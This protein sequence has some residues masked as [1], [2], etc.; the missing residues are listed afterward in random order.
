MD[1][2]LDKKSGRVSD[3]L[4]IYFVA[5]PLN[6]NDSIITNIEPSY[7]SLSQY[8]EESNKVTTSTKISSNNKIG[9]IE[10]W[11]YYRNKKGVNIESDT[12][13]LTFID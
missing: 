8:S 1:L 6:A 12:L 11:G 3:G 9:T 4:K 10:V 5:K 7:F 2:L 13:H